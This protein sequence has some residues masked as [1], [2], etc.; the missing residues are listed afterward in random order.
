MP[1]QPNLLPDSNHQSQQL[2][3]FIGRE[4][5][6]ASIVQ[7]LADS[8]CRLL[9]LIGPGGIG[10]T[11]L[12]LRAAELAEEHFTDGCIWI[13]L[14][15]LQSEELLPKTI[16]DTLGLTP[17]GSPLAHVSNYLHRKDLLLVFDNFEHLLDGAG[18]LTTLLAAAPQVKVLA[19][20]RETL[21]L[22]EEWVHHLEGLPYPPADDVESLEAYPAVELFVTAARRTSSAFD[23]EQERLAV[24]RICR[25]V[26]GMP[27]ALELAATWT[28]S[29]S[30]AEIAAELQN[31]LDLLTART[32]NVPA[33]HRSLHV[34]FEQTCAMLTSDAYAVF[35]QLS[36][37]R[38]G[39]TREAAEQVSGASL[40][41]LAVMVDKS[42]IKSDPNGRYSMHELV[43]Q[44]AAEQLNGEPDQELLARRR[45]A[46]FY[47][48]LLSQWEVQ[49]MGAHQMQAIAAVRADLDNIRLAWTQVLDDG[50]LENI[51]RGVRPFAHYGQ[52]QSQYAEAADVFERVLG[53]LAEMTESE[54]VLLTQVVSQTYLA[55]FYLRLGRLQ[56]AETMLDACEAIYAQLDIPPVPGF[57]TDPAFN[58]GILALIH[59]DYSQ[60]SEYGERMLSTSQLHDH[61]DNEQMAFHLLADAA[62]AAGDYPTAEKYAQQSYTLLRESGNR[63]FM[64]YTCNQLGSIAHAL[65][66]LATAQQYYET[67]YS[68]REEFNDPQ[69]MAIALR[70]LG[71]IAQQQASYDEARDRFETSLNIYSDINDPGGRAHV[72]FNLGLIDL[73]CSDYR[74]SRQHLRAALEI[75][76]DIQFESLALTILTT[77]AELLL[78]IGLTEHGGRLLSVVSQHPALSP[79]ASHRVQ[80]LVA[81]HGVE[82]PI[83][84]IND[85]LADMITTFVLAFPEIPE[86]IDPD[87]QIPYTPKFKQ[88]LVE[89]LTEREQEV[90]YYIAQGLSNRRIAE[91]MFVSLSTIKTHINNLYGKLGVLN[92]DEA[93]LRAEELNLL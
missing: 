7:I 81:D 89:P 75:A 84:S 27:L 29:L 93:L 88:D 22:H 37:F 77:I 44:Y 57:A 42:L 68:I 92:R 87:A 16:I 41:I 18:V 82:L 63:W 55:G 21:N 46:T 17:N 28:R 50:D 13:D 79:E 74:R 11:R 85:S 32:R 70:H 83:T 48:R 67:S 86:T 15:A 51:E 1:P 60:A 80:Q 40:A 36:V 34:V 53:T 76:A 6:V 8:S 26:A 20:S 90:L 3:P 71:E 33:R 38:G 31:G 24:A 35:K 64:A 19:T 23:Y 52:I 45:H 30:C 2:V 47:M 54:Q 9:T 72:L 49:L 12:A 91:T 59:G 61:R 73:I 58:R 14:Q 78:E 69:G 65:S 56:D 62:L 43:R 10:K 66:D 5:E 25:Y 4:E 39:F